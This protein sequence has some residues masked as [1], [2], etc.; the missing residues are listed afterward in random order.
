MIDIPGDLTQCVSLLMN[1]D[2][3]ETSSD[4]KRTDIYEPFDVVTKNSFLHALGDHKIS[5]S[6]D[7]VDKLMNAYNK[8]PA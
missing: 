2:L 7:T 1:L 8:L 3:L 6:E 5:A 4:E